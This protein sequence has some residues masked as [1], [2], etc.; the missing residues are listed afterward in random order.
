MESIS[1]FATTVMW[2]LVFLGAI[3]LINKF[4][5]FYF[6]NER[7]E[8]EQIAEA[9]ANAA[10]MKAKAEAN[11]AA[12]KAEAERKAKQTEARKQEKKIRAE[13]AMK[14]KEAVTSHAAKQIEKT[15][16]EEYGLKP[17]G[18]FD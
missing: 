4:F 7:E 11:A 1:N 6:C 14:A 17:K 10:A 3:A 8:A 9:E 2:C 5:I 12:M 16:L 13:C 18:W 15:C